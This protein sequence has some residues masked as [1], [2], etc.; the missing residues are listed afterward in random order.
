VRICFVC[1]E[2]ASSLCGGIGT[3]TQVLARSLG[4]AGHE[5]RV[6]GVYARDAGGP[7]Q[8]VDGGVAIRRLRMPAHRGGWLRAR[9]ALFRHVW[10]W[11]QRGEVDLVEVSDYEGWSAGWP[12]LRVPVVARLSG[13]STYFAAETGRPATRATRSLERAALRRADF[14]IAES[15]YVLAGTARVFN[16][17]PPPHVVLYNSVQVPCEVPFGSRVPNRIVFAGTLTEKKGIL[18]LVRAWPRVRAAC[19]DAELHIYGKDGVH[20]GRSMREY[21]GS[22]LGDGPEVSVWFH[23]HVPLEQLERAFQQA[24]AAV[25]PSYAEGFALT[26]LH[27]MACG[28]PTVFTRR[29]SGPELIAPGETGLL[30]D[31]DRPDEIADAIVSML[32]DAPLAERLGRA[33]RAVVARGFSAETCA[34]RNEL[35]YSRCVTDFEGR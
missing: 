27:A 18:S 6:I 31:P 12:R 4:G 2:Y 35:F 25:L 7:D 8:E 20:N 22:H 32:R 24:R 17:E 28:C 19:G 14:W 9:Y 34:A 5:V 21:I 30:V 11:S 3:L 16:L 1:N 33:G 15:D 26:P 29:S 10:H 13:S 23:G